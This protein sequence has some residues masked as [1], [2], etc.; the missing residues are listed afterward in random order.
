MAVVSHGQLWMVFSEIF[1]L[2]EDPEGKNVPGNAPSAL[3]QK[4]RIWSAKPSTRT[5][6][7]ACHGSRAERGQYR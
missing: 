4:T 6:C 2:T 7:S 5:A 1:R 3:R